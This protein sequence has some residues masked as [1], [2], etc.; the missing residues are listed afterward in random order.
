MFIS[1]MTCKLDFQLS[2][3]SSNIPELKAT[4]KSGILLVVMVCVLKDFRGPGAIL[5]RTNLAAIHII[6]AKSLIRIIVIMGD[7]N[8]WTN[9]DSL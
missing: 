8:F 9:E 4:I 1:S 2:V 5:S 7:T 6:I 3:H